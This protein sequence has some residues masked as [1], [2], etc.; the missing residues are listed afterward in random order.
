M[1]R[2]VS[3]NLFVRRALGS[4][5]LVGEN[6]VCLKC[7]SYDESG[8]RLRVTVVPYVDDLRGLR[9]YRARVGK[10]KTVLE[11]FI[12]SHRYRSLDALRGEPLKYLHEMRSA[13]ARKGEGVVSVGEDKGHNER[14]RNEISDYSLSK[15]TIKKASGEE[16]GEE[17]LNNKV[18][19]EYEV[20]L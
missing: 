18:T 11:V 16:V 10:T 8:W 2:S 9:G 5:H 1:G 19:R 20:G 4:D 15:E 6:L 14:Y 13:N 3:L 12:P 7:F 17:E